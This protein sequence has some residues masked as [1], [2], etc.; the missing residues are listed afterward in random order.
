MKKKPGFYGQMLSLAIPIALQNMLASSAHLVDTAMVTRLGNVA[1]SAVGV[2]G[3]WNL[4]MNVVLFGFC[5]GSAVLISQYWGAKEEHNIRRT[6]GLALFFSLIFATLYTV[7]GLMFPREMMSAF[8]NEKAVIDAGAEYLRIA[9]LNTLPLTYAM[10][11]CGARRATEDVK[12]PLLVS[13]VSVV[14]N[15]FFNYAYIY[16]HFGMPELGVRGA[17]VGTVLSGIAQLI[18]TLAFGGAQKHFTF[19]PLKELFSFN[20]KFVGLYMKIA[21]PVLLNETLWVIGFNLYSVIY[22]HQGSE[23]YAGYTVFDSVEQLTFVFF[24]GI[25]NACAIMTGKA[26]GESGPEKAFTVARKYLRIMPLVALI[27]GG[28]LIAIR[29]PVINLLHVET[30]YAATLAADILLFFGCWSSIR[31]IPYLCIVGIFRAGGDTRIGLLLDVGFTLCWGVPVTA[32][33]AYWFKVPFF[34][35]VCGTFMAED[36][37]KTPFCLWYFYSK[38]WIRQLAGAPQPVNK[39]LPEA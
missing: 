22:A 7:A 5:S 25:C 12:T 30:R 4:F 15:T 21:A 10:V 24:V 17:A 16:G 6:Y 2:A 29:W 20:R 19:A 14:V 36:L 28:L 13:G 26:V 32:A 34:W 23:N 27:V 33:L 18:L 8:T 31:Q 3:R 1:V 39:N 38:R 9:V 35:L 37:L 11:T